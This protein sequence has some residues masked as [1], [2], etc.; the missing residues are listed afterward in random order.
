MEKTGT[1]GAVEV[2]ERL[3]WGGGR[4]G[5]AAERDRGC[6]ACGDGE[7]V[8]MGGLLCRDVCLSCASSAAMAT[9]ALDE[10]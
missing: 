1:D 7:M 6:L 3:G 5:D 9:L 2:G 8:S 4:E 10:E